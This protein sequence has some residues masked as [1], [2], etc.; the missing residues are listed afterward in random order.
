VVARKSYR[1]HAVELSLPD[2]EFTD[3]ER[4]HLIEQH[5]NTKDLER[6]NLASLP[7]NPFVAGIFQT[8]HDTQK[9]YMA[10]EFIPGL[11]LRSRLRQIDGGFKPSET[12]FY[13]ANIVC[14]IGFLHNEGIA[15]CD[16]KP[17]NILLSPD[18]YL[19]LTDLGSSAKLSQPDGS[20]T[21]AGTAYYMA[22]ECQVGT[23]YEPRELPEAI[24]WWS[25][26]CVLY[27]MLTGMMVCCL[28]EPKF[29]WI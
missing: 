6:G 29:W 12:N 20:W 15:H 25:S 7:W 3:E 4:E 14:G 23:K 19:C 8:F 26:G 17:D 27:E 18:G 21:E 16:I 13:F 28:I 22:P 11:T 9:L 24:D 1:A 10:L 2:K 5:M